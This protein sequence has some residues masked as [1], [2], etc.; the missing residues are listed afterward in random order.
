[1][2]LYGLV[3]APNAAAQLQ[4]AEEWLAQ[5]GDNPVLLLTLGRLALLNKAPGKA[6][7][8]LEKSILL[9][10]PLEAYQELGALLEQA[11]EHDRAMELCQRALHLYAQEARMAITRPA[12]LSPH[13]RPNPATTH[14]G[15]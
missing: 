2:Q 5:Q 1:M 9:R 3:K 4:T 7:D 13:Q 8:Y 10:G 15:Y 6:R 14:Y 11:G 12:G